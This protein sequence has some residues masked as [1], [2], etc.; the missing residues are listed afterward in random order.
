MPGTIRPVSYATATATATATAWARS[1][2]RSSALTIRPP[3]PS[4]RPPGQR[5]ALPARSPRHLARFNQRGGQG[6]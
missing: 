1:R 5:L 2:R 6:R 4:A 3:S